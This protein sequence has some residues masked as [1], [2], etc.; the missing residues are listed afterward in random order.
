MKGLKEVVDKN[1]EDTNN[2]LARIDGRLQKLELEMEKSSQLKEGREDILRNEMG[3]EE[4]LGRQ[5]NPSKGMEVEQR[6]E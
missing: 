3:C 6:V 1:E 2:V 5:D 4:R